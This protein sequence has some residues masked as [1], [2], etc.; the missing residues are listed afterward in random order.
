[1]NNR[2]TNKKNKEDTFLYKYKN[3]D[4]Y[5]AKVQLIGYAIFIIFAIIY[6]NISNI[7]RNYDYNN[8]VS[9]NSNQNKD[10]DNIN[11]LNDIQ[12]NYNYLVDVKFSKKNDNNIVD[13]YNYTYSGKRYKDNTIIERNISNN[14]STFYK[15][16]D[17]YYTKENDDYNFID[18]SVVYDLISSK[19]I[20][21]DDIKK[22]VKKANLDHV[23]TGSNGIN[24]YKYSLLVRNIIQ[25]YKG[26]DLINIDVNIENDVLNININYDNLFKIIDK[27]IDSCNISYKYT[28]IGKVEEFIIIDNNDNKK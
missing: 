16:E 8:S 21:L 22:L 24:N 19:Y 15:I 14:K 26:E 11:L 23:T 28:D 10:I 4:K 6:I 1:M 13:N 3:D 5:K 9:N 7:G 27:N 12:D 17:E 2:D 25:S 20:E 18:S